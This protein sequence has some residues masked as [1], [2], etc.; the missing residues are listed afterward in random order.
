MKQPEVLLNSS[1]TQGCSC[2]MVATKGLFTRR[3]GYPSK[4]VNLSWRAKDSRVYKQNFTGREALQGYN[5]GQLNAWLHSKGLETI[6]KLT[7][8]GG[9]TLPGVF[10]RE[11]VNLLARVTLARR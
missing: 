8:V 6:R 9:L 2:K 1:Q 10:T 3:E 11:K 4:Q 5:P 7:R